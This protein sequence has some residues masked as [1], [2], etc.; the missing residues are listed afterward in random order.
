MIE[1][2][3]IFSCNFFIVETGVENVGGRFLYKK[4]FGKKGLGVEA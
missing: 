1:K 4:G 3:V 2:L